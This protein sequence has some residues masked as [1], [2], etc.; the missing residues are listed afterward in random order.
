VPQQKGFYERLKNIAADMR[1][2]YFDRDTRN[3]EEDK[4][5]RK[6]AQEK[7]LQDQID[8]SNEERRLQLVAKPQALFHTGLVDQVLRREL[9]HIVNPGSVLV[10]R[11]ITPPNSQPGDEI[12]PTEVERLRFG[13]VPEKWYNRAVDAA[14]LLLSFATATAFQYALF[15]ISAGIAQEWKNNWWYEKFQTY[16]NL[17]AKVLN[18]YF[19]DRVGAGPNPLNPNAFSATDVQLVSE[20]Y[21]EVTQLMSKSD[22]ELMRKIATHAALLPF[23]SN[24][25]LIVNGFAKRREYAMDPKMLE[26][27]KRI[28]RASPV[29]AAQDAATQAIALHMRSKASNKET[30]VYNAAS[31]QRFRFYEYYLATSQTNALLNRLPS[32]HTLGAWETVPDSNAL[33]LLPPADVTEA[34]FEAEE[35][36]GLPLRLAT[37]FATGVPPGTSPVSPAEV[38]AATAAR[39][40][41]HI[42]IRSRRKIRGANL[43]QTASASALELVDSASRLLSIVYGSKSRGAT[44]VAGDDLVWTCCRGGAVA[45]LAIRHLALFQDAEAVRLQAQWDEGLV[46]PSAVQFW[47]L[48]RRKI[49]DAFTSSMGRE[50][51]ALVRDYD[52][53]GPQSGLESLAAEAARTFAR[54]NTLMHHKERLDSASYDTAMRIVATSAAHVLFVNSRND[55]EAAVNSVV[56]FVLRE[57]TNANIFAYQKDLKPPEPSRADAS[58]VQATWASRIL[59]AQTSRWLPVGKGVDSITTALSEIELTQDE[60][61]SREHDAVYYCPMGSKL[62]A[63]PDR[64]PFAIDSLSTRIVWLPA[65]RSAAQHLAQCTRPKRSGRDA[66]AGTLLEGRPLLGGLDQGGTLPTGMARHPLAMGVRNGVIGVPLSVAQ[67]LPAADALAEKPPKLFAL[68][69]AMALLDS[70]PEDNRLVAVHVQRMRSVAFNCERLYF[71]IALAQSREVDAQ[72]GGDALHVDLHSEDDALALAIALALFETYRGNTV[73]SVT[74]YVDDS[75]A[76]AAKLQA[77]ARQLE[78]TIDEGCVACKLAELA[79]VL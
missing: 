20:I 59:A 48:P 49:V 34:V 17:G 19:A 46:A 51:R 13:M 58:V 42:I 68:T 1:L 57:Q 5:E 31:G 37:A 43:M 73:G 7:A 16:S 38:A 66:W 10:F 26:K 60:L 27:H 9:P 24:V 77:V 69:D 55:S 41:L 21:G 36:R 3:T 79:L 28:E 32:V 40:L 62:D 74:A 12:V 52:E 35:L 23:S 14:P 76:A 72:S 25:A 30:V 2:R 53:F 11:F 22:Y 61:A 71:A 18:L 39:E 64:T 63:L 6:R 15:N 65:L 44:F 47:K 29:E 33:R 4:E 70:D 8:L 67:R 45:R 75:D 50:M 78:S 54:V 56:A